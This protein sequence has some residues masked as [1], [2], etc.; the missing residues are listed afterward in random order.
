MSCINEHLRH[1]R[2]EFVKPEKQNKKTCG[3]TARTVSSCDIQL[4][5]S[6]V[7]ARRHRCSFRFRFS[8]A[9]QP[10]SRLFKLKEIDFESDVR[11]LSND[12]DGHC[13]SYRIVNEAIAEGTNG[14]GDNATKMEK[15]IYF[16]AHFTGNQLEAKSFDW[17]FRRK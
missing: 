12:A 7:G 2:C 6:T 14:R 11:Q 8:S 9:V 16:I 17:L 5:L 10:N 4:Y 1:I 3:I 15:Q 13:K